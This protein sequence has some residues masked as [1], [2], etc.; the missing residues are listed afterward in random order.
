MRLRVSLLRAM[1]EVQK[2]C[3]N[4]VTKNTT[5]NN[6]FLIYITIPNN[7]KHQP[8]D[9]H[10][11]CSIISHSQ[12]FQHSSPH[13]HNNM[14]FHGFRS[15]W[16]IALVNEYAMANTRNPAVIVFCTNSR[17]NDRG[18]VNVSIQSTFQQFICKKYMQSIAYPF[19]WNRSKIFL[20]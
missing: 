1:T 6:C 15:T 10:I 2:K 12:K 14:R 3:R 4:K 13:H 16:M 7:F 19:D 17:H 9:C 8:F 5:L 20:L 11:T 18:S